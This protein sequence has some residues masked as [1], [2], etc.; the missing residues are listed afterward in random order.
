VTDCERTRILWVVTVVRTSHALCRAWKKVACSDAMEQC[1][2]M[3]KLEHVYV[4][5]DGDF[6]VVCRL[7]VDPRYGHGIYI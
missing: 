3:R 4:K 7:V 5:D 2:P 1:D 6:M